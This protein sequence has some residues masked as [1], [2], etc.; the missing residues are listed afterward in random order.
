M[1]LDPDVTSASHLTAELSY[2]DVIREKFLLLWFEFSQ[3][4]VRVL[5][6]FSAFFSS[7]A[8]S[9]GSTR[10]YLAAATANTNQKICQEHR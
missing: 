4:T 8:G 7:S 9:R 3:G 6:Y 2:L 10:R 1:N 5:A